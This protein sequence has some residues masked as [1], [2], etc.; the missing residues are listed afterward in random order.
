MG[1][2]LQIVPTIGVYLMGI[3]AVISF[4]LGAGWMYLKLNH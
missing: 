4:I 3:V 1:N 2:I